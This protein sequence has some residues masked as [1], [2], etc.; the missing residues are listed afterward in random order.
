KAEIRAIEQQHTKAE[1]SRMRYE[2]RLERLQRE[3]EQRER[4]RLARAKKAARAKA[5]REAREAQ[6]QQA[7]AATE[8]DLARVKAR[9]PTLSPE[10]KQLKIAADTARMAL[11]KAQKQLNANPENSDL[12]AQVVQL[13]QA[14]AVAQQ[15]FEQASSQADTSWP[16]LPS[17]RPM[18]WATTV[19]APSCCRSWA[20]P[21]RGGR[22]S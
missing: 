20:R 3:A 7:G 8:P 6:E 12:Q 5:A 1:Q 16:W 18:P 17:A 4:D 13:E 15:A 9:I 22:C 2:Q 19:P 21:C 14:H 10:Q 11:Q